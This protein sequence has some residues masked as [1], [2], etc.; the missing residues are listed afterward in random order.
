MLCHYGDVECYG[1]SYL[2]V[3]NMWHDKKEAA[4]QTT[5]LLIA[6]HST[7]Q[8]APN[9]LKLAKKSLVIVAKHISSAEDNAMT[10]NQNLIQSL[11]FFLNEIIISCG[12]YCTVRKP[13]RV[14]TG[15]WRVNG[16]SVHCQSAPHFH[17]QSLQ[18]ALN[19]SVGV[20]ALLVCRCVRRLHSIRLR[21]P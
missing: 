20:I 6:R 9:S 4:R 15:W 12:E 11:L 7:C 19:E 3:Q 8:L 14:A 17:C 1:L 16:L 10:S 13:W 18:P 2:F 21:R 5:V